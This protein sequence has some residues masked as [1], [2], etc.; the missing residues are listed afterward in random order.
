MKQAPKTKLFL[1]LDYDNPADARAIFKKVLPINPYFKV[2]LELFSVAGPDIVREFVDSGGKVFLDLKFHDI[3]NTVARAVSRAVALRVGWLNIHCAGG[4]KMMEAAV[5]AK[6]ETCA[7]FGIDSCLLGV[8]VLT[9]LESADFLQIGF[10][11][12]P[13]EQVIH[14]ADLAKADGLDGV[15]CSAKEIALVRASCGDD[16]ITMV[17]GIRPEG[18]AADDQ[19]RT[20]TPSEANEEGAHNIVVGRPI[21]A[22]KDPIMALRN[23]LAELEGA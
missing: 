21:T 15:V 1:A 14:F 3:P 16:F 10:A 18:F 19:K 5:E 7:K 20:M 9:S 2:G 23:I 22:A 12:L 6:H 8:T 17:P 13:A 11:R 4:R